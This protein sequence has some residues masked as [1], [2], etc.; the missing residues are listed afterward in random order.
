MLQ[1]YSS[2]YVDC[3]YENSCG[4]R[5]VR[6]VCVRTGSSR[7]AAACA[8]SRSCRRAAA[9][10]RC[11]SSPWTRASTRTATS[12]RSVRETVCFAQSVADFVVCWP[13]RC[14]AVRQCVCVAISYASR[15]FVGLWRCADVRS[16]RTRLLPARRPHTLQALQCPANT[17]HDQQITHW[18][19]TSSTTSID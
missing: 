6:C 15:C 7:R 2:V 13:F 11:A 9:T 3:T 18:Y 17:T 4:M 8:I 14:T 16:G 19:L 1:W 10:K 12:A 5:T